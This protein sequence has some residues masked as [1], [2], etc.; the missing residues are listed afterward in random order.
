MMEFQSALALSGEGNP[1][2]G[3]LRRSLRV[4]IRPR[5]F[6]RGEP[7]RPAL[8]RPGSIVFQSALALSGEGNAEA[9][10]LLLVFDRFQSA[11]A[12]SG[13]GNGRPAV[14]VATI[15]SFNPPSPFRARG[16]GGGWGVSATV[17]PFQSAL[18]LSGEGNALHR[19][20]GGGGTRVSIRPRPFGRGEPTVAD[21]ETLINQVSIRPRPFGRGEQILKG[22]GWAADSFNPPSP[23][24]ARGTSARSTTV[25]P[26]VFQSALALSG[27][28]NL[29][30]AGWNVEP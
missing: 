7:S 8:D 11:L 4:S 17:S 26:Q 28:G 5:P 27:E 6:G 16:T 29:T 25:F 20:L 22:F 19:G 23:F 24:R 2:C 1:V 12:L 15:N 21:L 13:E 9:N 10:D 18:A 30:I 14:F 3:I